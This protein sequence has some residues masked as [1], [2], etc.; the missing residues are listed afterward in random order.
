MTVELLLTNIQTNATMFDLYSNMDGYTVPFETNIPAANLSVPYTTSLVPNN[1]TIIR[2]QSVGGVCSNHYDI[3]LRTTTTSTSSTSTTSTTSSSTS[4]TTTTMMVVSC[5]FATVS[6]SEIDAGDATDGTVTLQYRDC[7]FEMKEMQ[8]P[9]AGVYE[10]ILCMEQG[11]PIAFTY[12]KSGENM[13]GGNSSVELVSPCQE[14]TTS[15]STTTSTTTEAVPNGKC[16][17]VLIPNAA[18]SNGGQPLYVVYQEYGNAPNNLTRTLVTA[19]EDAGGFPG[20]TQ[21][22]ICAMTGVGI[23]FRYGLGG[24]DLT[25]T[26]PGSIVNVGS[27]D[28]TGECFGI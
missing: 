11:S 27:D 21:L 26:S 12:V 23:R 2:V 5:M 15:T 3:I 4:S 10:N 20:G 6:I 13:N 19:M 28:C 14:I 7:N 18:L 24:L 9:D 1:T 25:D 17:E 16:H 22:F 8:F